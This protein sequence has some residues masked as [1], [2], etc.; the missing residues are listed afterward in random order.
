MD[1][2]IFDDPF[3]DYKAAYQQIQRLYRGEWDLVLNVLS[4]AA[5]EREVM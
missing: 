2:D 5:L 4:N 1:K 3:Y